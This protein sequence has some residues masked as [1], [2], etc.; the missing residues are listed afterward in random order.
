MGKDYYEI[1]GVDKSASSD[2]IKKAY[3]KMAMKYHPDKN[4]GNDAESKFKEISE[5]YEVLSDDKKRS[6]YDRFGTT[7]GFSSGFNGGHGFSME[8]IFSNFGD[9]F[10]D[11]FGKRY[12]GQKRQKRG[13]DLRM[14]VNVTIEDVLKGT[15]KKLKYKR[16][17]KCETC[18]GKGG[19]DV[20]DC[21]SCDGSGRRIVVQ[22]TPFGQIRQE[23]PC[24]D[25]GGTGKVIRNVCKDCNGHGTN[26][27]DQTVDIEIP[28]GVEAGMQ[29][30]MT[31]F[32]NYTRDGIAGDLQIIIDEIKE[33][34]FTRQN[35]NLI[36]EKEIS[37]IDA[38]IGSN[39]V[40]KTPHG[41]MNIK[42]EPGTNHDSRIRINGKG[43][44]HIHYGLGDLYVVFK[45]KIPKE[46][47]LEE[48]YILE[49][50]KDSNNFKVK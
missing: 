17:D 42:V 50:L 16:Q 25:C 29:F 31:G 49:K 18:D 37:V 43:T 11:A 12:S 39:I 6:N 22:N 30:T 34:Y 20:K 33:D 45:V 46:I 47:N 27:I 9:V 13:S 24:P 4:S 40:V 36:I 35:N 48:K 21:L 15:T 5:A 14:K 28:A 8:D 38:I 19:T 10:G 41:N 2:Q 3:R 1:L 44:P 26:T 32:G 23:V 7:E